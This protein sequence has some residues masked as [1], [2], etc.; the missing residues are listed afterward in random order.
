MTAI[1]Y[2]DTSTASGYRFK[3]ALASVAPVPLV[4]PQVEGILAERINK[5]AITD[6]AQ[7]AM[8]ACSPIDDVR[9]S[10]RY[11]KWMVRNLSQSALSKVWESLQDV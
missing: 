10:A 2:P 11:R 1:G 7:A 6:A 9:A 4:V 3:L 5:Q 8:D